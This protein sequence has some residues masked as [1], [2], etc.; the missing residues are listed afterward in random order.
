MDMLVILE[1]EMIWMGKKKKAHQDIQIVD[2][3]RSKL[4]KKNSPLSAIFIIFVLS[5]KRWCS[6]HILVPQVF[7][8]LRVARVCAGMPA[9]VCI[10]N[11]KQK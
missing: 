1:R 7:V 3:K 9:K 5:L 10:A 2:I 11:P 4:K 6:C 8:C